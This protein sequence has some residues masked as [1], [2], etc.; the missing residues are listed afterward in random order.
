[1]TAPSTPDAW[2][3]RNVEEA[4]PY[5]ENVAPKGNIIKET[6]SDKLNKFLLD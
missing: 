6:L 4:K 1:V 5:V 2:I 3:F